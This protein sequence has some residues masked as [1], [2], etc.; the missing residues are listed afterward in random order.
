MKLLLQ[1][2]TIITHRLFFICSFLLILCF[3]RY[4]ES[5]DFE[6]EVVYAITFDDSI[7]PT[8]RAILP[9]Q[10]SLLIKNKKYHLKTES[11]LGKQ[12]TIYNHNKKLCYSLIDLFSTPL[13]IKKNKI[14]IL[15]DRKRHQIKDI[16]YTNDQKL[17]LGYNCKKVIITIYISQLDEIASLEAYFTDALGLNWINEADPVYYSIKGLLLEYDV[18]IRR[19]SMKYTVTDIL[20]RKITDR[21]LNIPKTYK[22]VNPIEAQLD[23]N[24][25]K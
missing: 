8:I 18:Q 9:Q 22:V 13:A 15:N 17:I 1:N 16:R 20:Q 5:K 6:G 3:P 2:N 14:D 4:A 10:A 11:G 23:F 12:S 7:D 21:E 24:K 25:R 19:A